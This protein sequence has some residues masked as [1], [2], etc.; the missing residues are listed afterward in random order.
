MENSI[1]ERDKSTDAGN[2]GRVP[3]VDGTRIEIEQLNVGQ[4]DDA[5]RIDDGVFRRFRRRVS[6]FLAGMYT[7]IG[8]SGVPHSHHTYGSDKDH[9]PI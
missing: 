2:S 7:G 4:P 6:Q 1:P 9:G 3:T 8:C 5:Q